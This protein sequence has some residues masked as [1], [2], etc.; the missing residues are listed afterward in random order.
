MMAWRQT[1]TA[2]SSQTGRRNGPS[3]S[4]QGVP[5]LN[6]TTPP[7]AATC[8]DSAFKQQ[9]CKR[10]HWPRLAR[11][12]QARTQK[13]WK[14][15]RSTA[16]KGCGVA[17]VAAATKPGTRCSRRKRRFPIPGVSCGSPTGSLTC[18]RR[19]NRRK[20]GKYR[21]SVDPVGGDDTAF[22]FCKVEFA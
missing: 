8:Y 12:A 19:Q 20:M 15:M 3:C 2:A 7:P 6:D 1:D 11:T 16:A 9:L 17:G 13:S 14:P 18:C 5:W 22:A 21:E 4:A 10:I